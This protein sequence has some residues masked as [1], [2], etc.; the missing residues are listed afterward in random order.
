MAKSSARQANNVTTVAPPTKKRK[1]NVKSPQGRLTT[2]PVGRFDGGSVEYDG[3]KYGVLVPPRSL[4]LIRGAKRQIESTIDF[5][6]EYET[7]LITHGKVMVD[8]TNI[9]G[10]TTDITLS[11]LSRKPKSSKVYVRLPKDKAIRN[12]LFACGAFGEVDIKRQTDG[13]VQQL[14]GLIRSSEE[15]DSGDDGF[16]ARKN[17]SFEVEPKKA[18]NLIRFATTHLFGEERDF[19]WLQGLLV[20]IM[21]NTREHSALPNEKE[22]WWLSVYINEELQI[23][24]FNF[25]DNGTGLLNKV[26]ELWEKK[27]GIPAPWDS[28][29]DLLKAVISGTMPPLK[30]KDRGGN[31]WKHVDMVAGKRAIKNLIVISNQTIGRRRNNEYCTINSRFNGTFLHWEVGRGQK[32]FTKSKHT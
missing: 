5:L 28:D 20:E 30:P 12:K 1:G 14:R 26:R 32:K 23:A 18:R 8:L 13:E 25:I 16:F 10:F 15:D 31:G 17:S 24:R 11:M 3:E 22:K 29:E 7:V 6:N 9:S 27:Y 19:L 4:S 21:L 2:T